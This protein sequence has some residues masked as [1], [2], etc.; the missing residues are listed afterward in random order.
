MEKTNIYPNTLMLKDGTIV[1]G[2]TKIVKLLDKAFLVK[3][4]NKLGKNGIDVDEFVKEAA[5][6]GELIHALIEGHFC[7]FEPDLTEFTEQQKQVAFK[8]FEK[9][10]EW[11]KYHQVEV[12]YCECKVVDEVLKYGGIIDIYGKI[13][14]KYSIIDIKTNKSISYEQFVQAS[15]Y[16]PL[17][18]SLGYPVEQI[19]ILNVP[20]DESLPVSCECISVES[21]SIYFDIFKNLLEI[22]YLKKRLGWK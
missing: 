12:I 3:W 6:Q 17:L 21:S 10:K 9:F 15:S 11:E 7:G 8:S 1:P 19:V 20:K 22:Y 2:A 5:R 18:Q 14:G 16:A 4:A 13:D